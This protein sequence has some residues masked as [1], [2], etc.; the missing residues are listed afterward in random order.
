M[1][2]YDSLWPFRRGRDN[3]RGKTPGPRCLASGESWRSAGEKRIPA[4]I[5]RGES[6]RE[7]SSGDRE[8]YPREM[9]V[10]SREISTAGPT[11]ASTATA[12]RRAFSRSSIDGFTTFHKV[13]RRCVRLRAGNAINLCISDNES[14]FIRDLYTRYSRNHT[15][16][17][18]HM[19]RTR[20]RELW[21]SD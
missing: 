19:Q 18:L 3:G 14:I 11:T 21:I 12:R 1:R 6:H 17:L 9:D 2:D 20:S 13:R 4:D 16:P 15:R 10:A 7:R 5:S 8:R